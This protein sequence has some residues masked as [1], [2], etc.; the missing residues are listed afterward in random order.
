MSKRKKPEEISSYY[1][2]ENPII[3]ENKLEKEVAAYLWFSVPRNLY[4]AVMVVPNQEIL[5]AH[6]YQ[7]LALHILEAVLSMAVVRF[8]FELVPIWHQS[9]CLA[10]LDWLFGQKSFGGQVGNLG[11][12][13]IWVRQFHSRESILVVESIDEAQTMFRLELPG[14]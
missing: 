10:L 6:E 12:S 8:D 4:K 1:L 5:K 14:K 2:W 7:I 11:Y 9:W 3:L 13:T